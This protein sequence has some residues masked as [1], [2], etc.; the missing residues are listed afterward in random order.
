MC[1]HLYTHVCLLWIIVVKQTQQNVVPAAK[2]CAQD[3]LSKGFC[4]AL[5]CLYAVYVRSCV[6]DV[7]QIVCMP[8]MSDHVYA[9]KPHRVYVMPARVMY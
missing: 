1:T 3:D 8:C 4:D 9:F 6:F 2:C 7:C 5:T